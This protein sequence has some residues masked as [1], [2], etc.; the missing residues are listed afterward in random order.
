MSEQTLQ[1]Y[2]PVAIEVIRAF[3]AQFYGAEIALEEDAERDRV[4]VYVGKAKKIVAFGADFLENS[5]PVDI[6]E[7]LAAWNIAHL[8]RTLERGCVLNVTSDGPEE[9]AEAAF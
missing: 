2:H 8:S 6:R 1:E 4:L 7:R 9:D 3:F 5:D